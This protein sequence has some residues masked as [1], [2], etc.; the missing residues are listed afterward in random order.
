MEQVLVRIS[1][2][3]REI[4]WR[5]PRGAVSQ[6]GSTRIIPIPSTNPMAECG[7]GLAVNDISVHTS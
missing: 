6:R 1:P 2:P 7:R 4:V 3:L 5:Y